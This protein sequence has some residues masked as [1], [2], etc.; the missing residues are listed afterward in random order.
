MG[1]DRRRRVKEKCEGGRG[2][3][4]EMGEGAERGRGLRTDQEAELT[5]A[6]TQ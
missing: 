4:G 2:S 3:K 5:D 1:K 6:G